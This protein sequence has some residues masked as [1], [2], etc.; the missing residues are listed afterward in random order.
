VSKN[1]HRIFHRCLIAIRN[2]YSLHH[3]R[4]LAAVAEGEHKPPILNQSFSVLDEEAQCRSCIFFEGILGKVGRGAFLRTLE[5][6]VA[7]P[8][9]TAVLAVGVPYLGTALLSAITAEDPTG[10][11]TERCFGAQLPSV[12]TTPLEPFP[13][14]LPR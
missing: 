9:H 10:E 3:H 13:R 14:L 7:L 12:G 1:R 6:M 2:I 5:F 4:L 8:Y 11:R